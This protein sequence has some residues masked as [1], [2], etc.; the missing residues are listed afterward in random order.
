MEEVVEVVIERTLL[1]VQE[2]F[3]YRI[4]PMMT[5]GG[6]H[7][8]DW[9]LANPLATCSLH[10][11]QRDHT[12]LL[13]LTTE[14]PK[15]GGP[16]G[17]T[18]PHL[19]AQCNIFLQGGNIKINNTGCK[20][21]NVN[22]GVEESSKTKLP[23]QRPLSSSSPLVLEHWV[24][25]VVDSSRYFT[26]RIS[27]ESTGREAVVGMGFRD[28]NDATNFKMSLQDYEHSI[29]KELMAMESLAKN[30]DM[31]DVDVDAT[32]PNTASANSNPSPNMGISKLSL[33]EGEKIHI[34]WKGAGAGSGSTSKQSRTRNQISSPTTN[35]LNN[36]TTPSNKPFL[37]KK[38]PSSS[39]ATF[40]PVVLNTDAV[41]ISTNSPSY[42]ASQDLS[43]TM[44]VAEHLDMNEEDEWGDFEGV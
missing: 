14:R 13:R 6:H 27:D 19:F 39:S 40:S 35:T 36:G 9:N 43:S 11:L 16:P 3:V 42:H 17:A 20:A 44:A 32:S 12:L 18:E 7:A 4:P 25:A 10:V 38:P 1:K 2:V 5:S 22:D 33:K 34:N 15:K 29:R 8:E 21:S 26:I 28:R 24:E 41:K 31:E 30:V 23:S 37:L